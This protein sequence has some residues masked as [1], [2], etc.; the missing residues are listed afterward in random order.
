VN[1]QELLNKY[2][3]S[4]QVQNFADSIKEGKPKVHLKGLV[5]SSDAMVAAA[6]YQIE[7][8]LN[9]FILPTHEEASY[10]LSDLESLFD[11]Q[12]L[13]FSSLLSESI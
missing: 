9:V 1:V 3:L 7:K 10:F 12:I 5:G 4:Q 13:F 8:R 2:S 11:N 6:T